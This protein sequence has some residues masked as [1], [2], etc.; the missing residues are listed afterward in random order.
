MIDT[1][2]SDRELN[3]W[4]VVLIDERGIVFED[5]LYHVKGS[6]TGGAS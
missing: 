6:F 2:E 1:D 4:T 3:L 5:G